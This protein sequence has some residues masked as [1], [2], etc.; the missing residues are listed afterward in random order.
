MVHYPSKVQLSRLANPLKGISSRHL[1]KEYNA[2]VRR[3]LW[4]GHFWPGSHFAGSCVG[5]PPTAV[6]VHREPAAPLMTKPANRADP[7]S[8]PRPEQHR[9]ALHLPSERVR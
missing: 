1:S 7:C 5:A 8:Q 3:H 6:R 9:N 2:H 4:G